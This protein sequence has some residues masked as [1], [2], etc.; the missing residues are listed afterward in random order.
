VAINKNK[1]PKNK[2]KKEKKSP[3]SL[4]SPCGQNVYPGN[5]EIYIVGNGIPALQKKKKKKNSLFDI[6]Y[7]YKTHSILFY[8]KY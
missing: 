7:K 3:Q 4:T 5:H 2:T 8:S 1:K 6:N